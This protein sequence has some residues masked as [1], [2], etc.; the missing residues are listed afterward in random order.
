MFLF[1][2][3]AIN[4]HFRSRL[5]KICY[6]GFDWAPTSPSFNEIPLQGELKNNTCKPILFTFVYDMY[7][8]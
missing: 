4:V 3:K 2:L 5:N 8:Q 1:L 6:N 7:K